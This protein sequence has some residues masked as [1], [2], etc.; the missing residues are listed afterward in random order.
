MSMD[1]YFD[2]AFEWFDERFSR[3]EFQL[4]DDWLRLA[5]FENLTEDTIV[6]L[7]CATLPAKHLLP[8]RKEFLEKAYN[9]LVELDLKDQIPEILKGLE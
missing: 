6:A 4:A 1:D 3:G 2:M 7:L 8:S 9:R 5:R